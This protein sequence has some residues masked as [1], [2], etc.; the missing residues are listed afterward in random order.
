MVQIQGSEIFKVI[1]HHHF[2]SPS[3]N[4]VGCIKQIFLFHRFRELEENF[5]RSHGQEMNKSRIE[6]KY[7]NCFKK[8]VLQYT[9]FLLK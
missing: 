5:P 4:S 9:L 6:P 7:S 8:P 2:I 3:E 1:S